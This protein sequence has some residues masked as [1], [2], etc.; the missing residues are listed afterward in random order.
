MGSH[1]LRDAVG[2]RVVLLRGWDVEF[3]EDLVDPDV[4]RRPPAAD[5]V[6]DQRFPRVL[7]VVTPFYGFVHSFPLGLVSPFLHDRELSCVLTGY[8][9]RMKAELL[10]FE[11]QPG[12]VISYV[13]NI[14][15]RLAN[16]SGAEALEVLPMLSSRQST[17]L[18]PLPQPEAEQLDRLLELEFDGDSPEEEAPF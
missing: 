8:G 17:R 7:N 11:N 6:P 15:V 14:L 1:A 3:F 10:P 9:Q 4:R 16:E 5:V 18:P 2:V 13:V 12:P